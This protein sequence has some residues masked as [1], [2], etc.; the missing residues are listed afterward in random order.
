LAIVRNAKRYGFDS[1]KF[2]AKLSNIKQLENREK[3]LRDNY[4]VLSNKEVKY[5]EYD[6]TPIGR[7]IDKVVD[8]TI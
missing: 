2:V 7:D 4:A 8:V 1:K 3:R 5:K 6:F